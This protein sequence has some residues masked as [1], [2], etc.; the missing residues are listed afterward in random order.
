[1]GAVSEHLTW[2]RTGTVRETLLSQA[3][4]LMQ[5]FTRTTFGCTIRR[6]IA[7]AQSNAELQQ[8][9]V[10]NFLTPRRSTAKVVLGEAMRNG[11]LRANLDLDVLLDLV[12]DP[13]YLRLLTRH[14][15]LDERFIEKLVDMALT[16]VLP[17]G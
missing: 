1:L 7:D 6:V 16:G 13:I 8:A 4:L 5:L 3:T 10:D 11:E 17:P 12:F 15:P 14:A 9:F 2:T